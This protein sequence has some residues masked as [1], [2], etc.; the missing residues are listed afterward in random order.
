M[1][2]LS[3][4]E[5]N[6][7]VAY[8]GVSGGY[9]GDFSYASHA[10]FYPAYCG[11]EIDPNEFNGTTRERFIAIL[12]QAD[13]L[14]QSKIIQGVIEKYPL[15]RFEDRFTDGYLTEGEFKQKQRIYASI[16]SWIQELKGKGLLKVQDLTYNYQFV[17]ET[18]DHCQTLISEH[19]CRSAVDRAHTAL[20]GYL[21][22]TCNNAGLTITESNPKIQDYWSKLKQKH[23][24][25][26]IDNAESH[27][28]INQIINAIGK[29]LENLNGIRNNR[30]YSHPNEQIIGESE[31]KL[32]INLFRSILQYIDSKV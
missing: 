22:E 18:L 9:L 7:V 13:P 21:K 17:Q 8:I 25:I 28:P 1:E 31:A 19:D 4:K 29:L 23:P 10:E 12:S 11:L 14:V 2:R 5:V 15:D 24:N 6:S 26:L 32:V 20:H 30:S 27:L 3:G 16:L